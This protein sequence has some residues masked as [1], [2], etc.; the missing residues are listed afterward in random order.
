MGG[1]L[2]T[3]G[4]L[5]FF[6]MAHEAG[7]FIAAKM[8]HM[9]ATEFFF[10]FGKRIVSFTRGE[11][12]YGIKAIPA[13][14]YVRIIG[15]NP[16]EEVPAEDIGR[17]YREKKF[18]E[19]SFV[20]LAGVAINLVLGYLIFFAVLAVNGNLFE[21]TVVPTVSAVSEPTDE[22]PSPAAAAGIEIGDVIVAIDGVPTPDWESTV[23]TIAARPGAAVTVD[24]LRGDQPLAIDVT[25]ASLPDAEGGQRG[26]LGVSPTE[27]VPDISVGEAVGVAGRQSIEA[28]S[29]SYEFLWDM[30]SNIDVLA[31][32][33]VGGEI[34]VE[35]RPVSIIGMGQIGA[36]SEALGW[37]AIFMFL[38]YINIVL[39]V[40]NS[41]P[42]FPLDGG[43]FAV[44]V[45]EKIA[46]RAANMR[47]LMPI[48]A[49]VLGIF[50]FLGVVSLY[51]DVVDPIR[52]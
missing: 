43:H 29:I 37:P 42:L 2:L 52:F 9:K 38:G 13:G 12:E 6:V 51:L 49:T 46:G 44:A 30:V 33:F 20:V 10:G 31:R 3:V 26:F 32:V 34:P 21:A 48:A 25:L 45:Y 23:D 14:G 40:M 19:K 50:V 35:Q 17:T 8:T 27:F 4:G 11:T 36:Q 5:F 18:W 24:V 41:L 15:M 16:L 47:V 7:H 39:A 22:V 1:V 28:I